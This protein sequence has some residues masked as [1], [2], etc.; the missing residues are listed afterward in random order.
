MKFWGCQTEIRLA[1]AVKP[2]FLVEFCIDSV[3]SAMS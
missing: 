1:D 2:M 3:V